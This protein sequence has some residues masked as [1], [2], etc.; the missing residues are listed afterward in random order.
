MLVGPLHHLVLIIA[1]LPP[2]L[3][4]PP[5]LLLQLIL[6]V[7][8]FCPVISWAVPALLSWLDLIPPKAATARF[9]VIVVLAALLCVAA[10]FLTVIIGVMTLKEATIV[11]LMAVAILH[12]VVLR[13][14]T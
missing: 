7:P 2:T 5:N 12:I 6:A 11:Y 13:W 1:T 8:I 14:L 4:F 3:L 9:R 10:T